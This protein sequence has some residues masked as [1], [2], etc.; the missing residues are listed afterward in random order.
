MPRHQRQTYHIFSRHTHL[1][2]QMELRRDRATRVVPPWLRVVVLVVVGTVAAAIHEPF[3]ALSSYRLLPA[4][5]FLIWFMV[6]APLRVM[7]YVKRNYSFFLFDFWYVSNVPPPRPASPP[8][9]VRHI[10]V[11]LFDPH[12]PS[13]V[14]NVG[15]AVVFALAILDKADGLTYWRWC[16]ALYAHA[17]G[18]VAGAMLV[19]KTKGLG[20]T[21]Q[22]NN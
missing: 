13:Y 15:T 21:P 17:E 5:V 1:Y 16:L 3:L 18:P 19:W 7:R 8:A 22:V 11:P 14:V 4:V 9:F 20:I 12:S 10:F 2:A 6:A